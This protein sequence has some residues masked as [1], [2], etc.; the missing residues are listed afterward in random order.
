MEHVSF[1]GT[2]IDFCA[3][4]TMDTFEELSGIVGLLAKDRKYKL[5]LDSR[6]GHRKY[7]N[8]CLTI[9]EPFAHSIDCH[10]IRAESGAIQIS[11]VFK[12]RYVTIDS[13]LV[14]HTVGTDSVQ[15]IRIDYTTDMQSLLTMLQELKD[16]VTKE[17]KAVCD[18]LTGRTGIS[19]ELLQTYKNSM[20]KVV[21][22]AIYDLGFANHLV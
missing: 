10:I 11:Q 19:L 5:N 6:G 15:N 8:K 12:N 7:I 2:T 4:F 13:E 1:K 18:F 16:D 14:F 3:Y 22:Y 17:E 20:K 9:L 21:G